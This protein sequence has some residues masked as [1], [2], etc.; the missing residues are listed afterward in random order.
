MANCHGL[1]ATAF[2]NT[3]A[4]GGRGSRSP[5]PLQRESLPAG[6]FVWRALCG[7]TDSEG[8]GGWEGVPGWCGCRPRR[9]NECRDRRV[10][11]GAAAPDA[12][13]LRGRGRRSGRVALSG[14]VV[15]RLDLLQ[16]NARAG[17]GDAL[18]AAQAHAADFQL[19]LLSAHQVDGREP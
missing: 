6:A 10:T 4:P 14:L 16:V 8:A 15:G 7:P 2:D 17:S 1:R 18:A 13:G 19:E 3:K 12:E 5:N 9:A 11:A